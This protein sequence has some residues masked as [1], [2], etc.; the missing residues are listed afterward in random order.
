M[1]LGV[2]F[3]GTAADYVSTDDVNLLDA[4]TAHLQQGKGVWVGDGNATNP[5]PTLTAWIQTRGCS[6]RRVRVAASRRPSRCAKPRPYPPRRHMR[7]AK[8]GSARMNPTTNTRL[9]KTQIIMR[10]DERP[11]MPFAIVQSLRVYRSVWLTGLSGRAI[12]AHFADP[13]R[14]PA[15][16]WRT[17]AAR[18][19]AKQTH[20][21]RLP[22]HA[23]LPF[24]RRIGA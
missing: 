6:A 11:R 13:H 21:D 8:Y 4:D 10:E 20:L 9:Y 3:G 2:I 23:S 12:P 24:A 17:S 16:A 18:N 19:A 14:H 22:D 5:S 7:I 1:A 15:Y